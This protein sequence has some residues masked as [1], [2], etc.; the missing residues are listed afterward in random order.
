MNAVEQKR[1][2]AE[3]RG[4]RFLRI[5]PVWVEMGTAQFRAGAGKRQAI[6]VQNLRRRP[7]NPLFSACNGREPSVLTVMAA[8]W[9]VRLHLGGP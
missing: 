6:L 8:G 3:M 5:G 7:W 4:A 1:D 9:M 2:A